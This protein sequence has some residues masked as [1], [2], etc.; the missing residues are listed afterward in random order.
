MTE[1]EKNNASKEFQDIFV[2]SALE[3]IILKFLRTQSMHGYELMSTIKKDFEVLLGASTV[4]PLLTGIEKKG[5][6]KSQWDVKNDR[7]R[8][9]YSITAKGQETL[10]QAE[11]TFKMFYQKVSEIPIV[12]KI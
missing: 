2:R 10:T 12:A 9:I 6:I 4:Y 7:P 5:N 3:M 1:Q 11:D 8:K